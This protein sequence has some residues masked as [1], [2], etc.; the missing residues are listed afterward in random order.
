MMIPSAGA[1]AREPRE[2]DLA[3]T[4]VVAKNIGGIPFVSPPP[5]PPP[6]QEHRDDFLMRL[7][8]I[9][10]KYSAWTT[11][12]TGNPRQ[13]LFLPPRISPNAEPV[14]LPPSPPPSM[15]PSTRTTS[16][17]ESSPRIEVPPDSMIKLNPR[18]SALMMD[19][20]IGSGITLLASSIVSSA[21]ASTRASVSY[22]NP[23]SLVPEKAP[24]W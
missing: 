15:P 3:C 16:P 5:S 18:M 22:Q 2:T 4:R 11:Q 21:A 23:S 10:R 8:H 17:P 24:L 12:S 9:E 20:G 7:A 19:H 13:P 1:N 6:T 14:S